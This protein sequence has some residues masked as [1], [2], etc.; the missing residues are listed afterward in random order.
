MVQQTIYELIIFDCQLILDVI[1]QTDMLKIHLAKE[2]I[3]IDRSLLDRMV[4]AGILCPGFT[5]SQ[6]SILLQTADKPL[7]PADFKS[8]ALWNSQEQSKQGNLQSRKQQHSID[9]SYMCFNLPHRLIA[10]SH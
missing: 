6:K 10:T 5:D 1:S 7:C 9:E 8:L 2:F 4:N 3:Q